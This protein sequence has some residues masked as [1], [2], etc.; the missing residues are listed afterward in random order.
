MVGPVNRH[1]ASLTDWV[2]IPMVLLILLLRKLAV[3]SLAVADI[4]IGAG[5]FELAPQKFTL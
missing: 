5:V 1:A 4:S 3:S 2:S